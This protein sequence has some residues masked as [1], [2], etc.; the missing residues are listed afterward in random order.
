MACFLADIQRHFVKCR[1][2]ICRRAEEIT[3]TEFTYASFMI[4]DSGGKWSV[5]SSAGCYY[6]IHRR[7]KPL[8]DFLNS[9][10]FD[11]LKIP[12]VVIWLTDKDWKRKAQKEVHSVRLT[13][14]FLRVCCVK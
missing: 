3:I 13:E 7:T 11:V 1:A 2:N 5:M 8:Y 12:S 14:G 10:R 6:V 9:V 4:H